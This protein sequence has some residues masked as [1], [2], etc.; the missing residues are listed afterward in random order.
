MGA[1]EA[2]II[3]WDTIISMADAGSEGEDSRAADI[4]FGLIQGDN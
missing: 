3:K 4:P 2:S 1:G